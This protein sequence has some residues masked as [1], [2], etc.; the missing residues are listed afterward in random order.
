MET[1][2][3]SYFLIFATISN[4]NMAGTL[5]QEAREPLARLRSDIAVVT[6]GPY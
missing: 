2:I 6:I 5:T 4:S 1:T 3:N